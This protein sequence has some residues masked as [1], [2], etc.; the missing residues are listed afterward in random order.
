MRVMSD[1][2]TTI[3]CVLINLLRVV[4]KSNPARE[5]SAVIGRMNIV[6]FLRLN[7]YM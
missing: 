5:A 1:P 3:K 7:G 4:V 2:L 6:I